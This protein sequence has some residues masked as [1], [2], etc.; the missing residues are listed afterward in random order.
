MPRKQ[1]K[2]K[3]RGKTSSVWADPY[4]ESVK[5]LLR[6]LKGLLNVLGVSADF[7]VKEIRESSISNR[8]LG[9]RMA[10]AFTVGE[11]L[12][13]WH[14]DPRYLDPLGKP[15]A[16]KFSGRGATFSNLVLKAGVKIPPEEVLKALTSTNTVENM[17]N[18]SIRPRRRTLTVFSDHELAIHHTFIALNSIV[19]TLAHNLASKPQNA[20][21]RFHRIA[22]SSNLTSLDIDRLRIWLNK[23]GQGFLETADD[24]MRRR[25]MTKRKPLGRQFRASIGT[26]LSVE[27]E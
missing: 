23:H 17:G 2:K 21:Q 9:H 24:W 8:T 13:Y 14:Q 12:T 22:W 5:Q 15:L 18:G 7:K 3:P 1:P 16:L 10:Y 26:Y 6:D 19:T 25:K 27:R 20:E 11:I 4:Q